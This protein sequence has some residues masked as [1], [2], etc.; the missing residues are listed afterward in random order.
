MQCLQAGKRG[1]CQLIKLDYKDGNHQQLHSSSRRMN[2][3]EHRLFIDIY[4]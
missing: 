4:I 2:F 3:S 1:Q